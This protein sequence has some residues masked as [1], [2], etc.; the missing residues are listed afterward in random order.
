M[1]TKVSHSQP[2]PKCEDYKTLLEGLAKGYADC[3][4]WCHQKCP[5]GFSPD[6]TAKLAAECKKECERFQAQSPAGR[7]F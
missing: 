7:L 2:I 6:E 1:S 5:V 3:A 4:T